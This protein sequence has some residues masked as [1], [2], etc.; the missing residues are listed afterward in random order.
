MTRAFFDEIILFLSP[1]IAYAIWLM[2]HRRSPLHGP[3]WEGKILSLTT[4][5]LVL[6]VASFIWLGLT[7]NKDQGAYVPAHMENGKLV[8]AEIK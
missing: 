8:P 6:L 3:H 2:I 1:F 7:A 4:A 5:G